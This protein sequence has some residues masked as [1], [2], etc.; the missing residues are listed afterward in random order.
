MEPMI[1]DGSGAL[2]PPLCLAQNARRDPLFKENPSSQSRRD[3]E[4]YL[5]AVPK[6]P[7]ASLK[8]T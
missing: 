4:K 2:A 1:T 8:H 3:S 5:V 7:P 6:Y